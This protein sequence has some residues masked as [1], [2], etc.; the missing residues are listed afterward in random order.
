MFVS[1]TYEV[2]SEVKLR[3]TLAAGQPL[4]PLYRVHGNIEILE[5]LQPAQVLQPRDGVVLQKEIS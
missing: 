1:V 4:H 3:E 5:T 2:K